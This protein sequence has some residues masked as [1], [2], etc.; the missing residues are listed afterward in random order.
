MPQFT[1]VTN[2]P[3]SLGLVH[4]V[5]FNVLP[6]RKSGFDGFGKHTPLPCLHLSVA[7]ESEE[8]TWATWN[9]NH[10]PTGLVPQTAE[11]HMAAIVKHFFGDALS[12][13][14]AAWRFEWNS[15][16]AAR[17]Q[18]VH[19]HLEVG[20]KD[21]FGENGFVRQCVESLLKPKIIAKEAADAESSRISR[22]FMSSGKSSGG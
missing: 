13:E 14:D 12:P 15:P 11:D 18:T 10:G 4:D 2:Y 1:A 21:L 22:N 8:M 6:S 19:F 20:H 7:A 9:L 3:Y 17:R 16:R 5:A